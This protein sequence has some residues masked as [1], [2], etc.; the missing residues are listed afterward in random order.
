[1]KTSKM[2]NLQKSKNLLVIISVIVA[3]IIALSVAY[4]MDYFD[5]VDIPFINEHNSY[6]TVEND[7]IIN[8]DSTDLN[9]DIVDKLVLSY[10]TH[11]NDEYQEKYCIEYEYD[12]YGRLNYKK[13]G[14]YGYDLYTYTDFEYDKNGN[15]MLCTRNE[16][17]KE[18]L[19][20]YNGYS[21]Y[22]RYSYD[23]NGNCLSI[24]ITDEDNYY[25]ETVGYEYNENGMVISETTNCYYENTIG[26]SICK[27]Y[28]YEYE[29][30][31]C[32]Q[33]IISVEEYQYDED[34][35]LND[36]ENYSEIQKF[37]YDTDGN[38]IKE[39]LLIEEENE[40]NF[41]SAIEIDGNYYRVAE[42][43]EFTWVELG[44]TKAKN[45]IGFN[46][47]DEFGCKLIQIE[48]LEKNGGHIFEDN[49][50]KCVII[51]RARIF[52]FYNNKGQMAFYFMKDGDI[53]FDDIFTYS[54][55]DNDSISTFSSDEGA[56][57]LRITDRTVEK[58]IAVLE[59]SRDGGFDSDE[60]YISYNLIDES[61]KPEFYEEGD[62][63]DYY[64]LYLK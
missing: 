6:N 54:V 13:F 42:N 10:E 45:K 53:E 24:D 46:N 38:K 15:V 63:S 14:G 36:K 5:V 23:K 34:G 41:P 21:Q 7:D 55:L 47:P 26:D 32:T 40:K 11:F 51:N 16:L 28:R 64:K 29:N 49:Q 2:Q 17:D 39:Q 31:V 44:E 59:I 1:M 25:R 18:T 12:E 62:L 60:K 58:N 48:S 57:M 4:A 9:Q 52:E 3:L 56:G 50:G 27:K 30:G 43:I 37:F 61:R 35:E 33:A 8:K 22:Y 20:R 19:E